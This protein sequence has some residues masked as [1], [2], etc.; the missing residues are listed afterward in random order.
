MC[1]WLIHVCASEFVTHLQAWMI[2]SSVWHDGT[3]WYVR[4]NLFIWVCDSF[5]CV[6]WLLH[7]SSWLIRV[8][9]MT[10][11]CKR[12]NL[13]KHTARSCVWH[14]S[15]ICVA[16]LTQ[17]CGM[18]HPKS[19]YHIMNESCHT[20][21]WVMSHMNEWRHTCKYVTNS[22]LA[23]ARPTAPLRYQNMNGSCHIY[24][25]VIS[26]VCIRHI[27]RVNDLRI[28]HELWLR[29][30]T[31]NSAAEISNYER[32]VS[33]TWMRHATYIHTPY[34]T[35]KSVTNSD[36]APVRPKALPGAYA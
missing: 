9:A 31:P 18:T 19:K 21:K 36:L 30:T 22:D 2:H 29:T 7:M 17:V 34:H 15:T 4:H 11:S 13:F 6:A 24:E 10:P 16:W 5:K 28:R 23:P 1:G 3:E 20:Y 14:D 27:T 8:C 33:H 32:I 35:W 25:W 12:N 26:H